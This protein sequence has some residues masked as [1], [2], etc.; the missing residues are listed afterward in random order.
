MKN[1]YI[2]GGNGLI[3]K[4]IVKLYSTDNVNIFVLDKIGVKKFKNKNIKFIKYDC[5]DVNNAQKKLKSLFKL[6]GKPDIFI[7]SS[8]PGS[9]PSPYTALV[10]STAVG[11]IVELGPIVKFL[12][13]S[14]AGVVGDCWG[15]MGDIAVC[16]IGEAPAIPGT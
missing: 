4:Q 1:I 16:D 2:L 8:S 7:N 14:W 6:Y 12:G 13:R 5:S 10:V 15:A 3:G 9:L 11:S